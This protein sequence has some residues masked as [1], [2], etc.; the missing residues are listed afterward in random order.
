MVFEKQA[1][2][3]QSWLQL[4][5]SVIRTAARA[6]RWRPRGERQDADDVEE[7]QQLDELEKPFVCDELVEDEGGLREH[8]RQDS[9]HSRS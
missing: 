2:E 9:Q 8:A 6:G 7:E 4:D 1:W 5:I 3:G